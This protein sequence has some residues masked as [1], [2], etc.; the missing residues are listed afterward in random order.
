MKTLFSNPQICY[1]R[2][3]KI[4]TKVAKK[5]MEQM[6]DIS[7]RIKSIGKE[8]KKILDFIRK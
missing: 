7:D 6:R 5:R 1:K 2:W 3:K 8:D 4:K